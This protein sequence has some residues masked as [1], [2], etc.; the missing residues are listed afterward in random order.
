VVIFDINNIIIICSHK[1]KREREYSTEYALLQ[2]KFCFPQ[3]K[4]KKK[5]HK[6]KEKKRDLKS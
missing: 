4:K 1:K 2:N 6:K 3:P 5:N